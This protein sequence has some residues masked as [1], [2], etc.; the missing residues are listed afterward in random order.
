V[1]EPT[2]LDVVR[3]TQLHPDADRR[4]AIR[5]FEQVSARMAQLD[6]IAELARRVV[7]PNGTGPLADRLMLLNLALVDLDNHP[8]TKPDTN[9]WPR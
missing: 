2:P 1:S 3:A 7:D 5:A 4:A 9:G 6:R 8:D